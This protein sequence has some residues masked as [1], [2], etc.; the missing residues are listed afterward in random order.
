MAAA[1]TPG[2]HPVFCQI[3]NLNFK[4]GS[5]LYISYIRGQSNY[6]SILSLLETYRGF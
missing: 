6:I 1:F 5:E 2:G 4:K 3:L